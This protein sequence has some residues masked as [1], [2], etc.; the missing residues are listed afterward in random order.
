M[1]DNAFNLM[2]MRM[3]LKTNFGLDS[4]KALS[5]QEALNIFM[6]DRAKKCCQKRIQMILMDIIMPEMDGFRTTNQ[7]MDILMQER[8]IKNYDTSKDR[9]QPAKM[10]AE[11]GVAIVA[12]TAYID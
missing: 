3:I 1:D 4:Y 6:K 2:P 7:I 8:A 5:G 11:M 9:L 12:I 10:A